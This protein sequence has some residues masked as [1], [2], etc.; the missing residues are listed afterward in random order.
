MHR[1]PEIESP[2]ALARRLRNAKNAVQALNIL[3][4]CYA[5]HDSMVSQGIERYGVNLAC[6]VGCDLCCF[7]RVGAKAHEVLLIA[8]AVKMSWPAE[9]RRTLMAHLSVNAE[10]ARQMTRDQQY[11][12]NLG[13]ILGHG[14]QSFSWG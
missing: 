3:R 9:A 11:A 13:S 8:E 1:T 12:V 7:L 10:K 5:A 14:M 6:R 2:D 4:K